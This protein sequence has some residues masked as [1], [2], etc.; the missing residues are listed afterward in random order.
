MKLQ[1]K[2]IHVPRQAKWILSAI[3]VLGVVRISMPKEPKPVRSV[4]RVEQVQIVDWYAVKPDVREAFLRAHE[5]ATSYAER[6]VQEWTGELRQRAEEDFLPWYFAYWNQQAMMLKAAGYYLMDTP[7]VEGML[8]RQPSAQDKMAS[9][10][11]KAFMARVLQPGSAQLR[12]ETITRES[13]EVFL[14]SLNKELRALE[15]SYSVTDQAWSRHLDGIAGMMGSVEG[16]RQVPLVLKGLSAGST[17]AAV[18][19]G[20]SVSTQIR[21]MML[22]RGGRELMEDGMMYA[23]RAASRSFGGIVFAVVTAWDLYD[24]HRTVSQNTPVMRQ[25]LNGY[26]DEL[27]NQVL[28]DPQ[29]GIFQTLETVR[30]EIAAKY[31]EA[32]P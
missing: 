7:L 26:F 14:V 30:Q 29:C 32:K 18:K 20:K 8:G 21:M 10:L 22:R 9:L 13:V 11:E 27:E 31:K 28:H 4:D 19:I 23:G 2:K 15:V 16:N 3:A 6:A 17:V 5:K 12:V 24:H 1:W 25:L